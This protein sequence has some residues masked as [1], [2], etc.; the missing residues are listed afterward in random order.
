[1]ALVRVRLSQF[2]GHT[3]GFAKD[4]RIVKDQ[5]EDRVLS[6]GCKANSEDVSWL[7]N[8]IVRVDSDIWFLL[9]LR[10]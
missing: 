2:L 7:E 8:E 10:V 9:Y 4:V 3:L 1:M 6:W 5:P